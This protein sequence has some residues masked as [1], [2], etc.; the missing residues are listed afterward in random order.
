MLTNL[1]EPFIDLRPQ[2]EQGYPVKLLFKL[3]IDGKLQR[4]N[5][6][7]TKYIFYTGKTDVVKRA[8]Y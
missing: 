2:G 4:E 6:P 7:S 5:M 3:F 1:K 8:A